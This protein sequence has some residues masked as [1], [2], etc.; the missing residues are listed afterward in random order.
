[1]LLFVE[2]AKQE[3]AVSCCFFP[4]L[5]MSER[6]I[7]FIFLEVWL[8]HSLCDE[9]SPSLA[10]TR[11]TIEVHCPPSFRA[12]RSTKPSSLCLAIE[13]E[14][15]ASSSHRLLHIVKEQADR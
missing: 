14:E 9:I 12:T 3:V 2:Y 15:E 11:T 1:M 10:Q 13:R 7:C 8:T 5:R 4:I 6:A